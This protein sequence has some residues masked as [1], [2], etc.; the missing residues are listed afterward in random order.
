VCHVGHF[1]RPIPLILAAVLHLAGGTTRMPPVIAS[2]SAA[3]NTSASAPRSADPVR[4][5]GRTV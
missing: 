1:T 2:E 3:N 5:P 4:Q